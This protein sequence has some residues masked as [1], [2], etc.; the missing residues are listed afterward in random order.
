MTIVRDLRHKNIARCI[1]VIESRTHT[2]IVTDI[3]AGG[4]LFDFLKR[5]RF[6]TGEVQ[7]LHI[8]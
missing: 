4:E 5:R 3:V 7:F 6:F 8:V 2:Y 1:E